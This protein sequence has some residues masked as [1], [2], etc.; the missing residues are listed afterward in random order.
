MEALLIFVRV[1]KSTQSASYS[2]PQVVKAML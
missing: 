2:L 1:T